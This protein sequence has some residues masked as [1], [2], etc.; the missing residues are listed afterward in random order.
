M[1][2][3]AGRHGIVF[4]T[5]I[6]DPIICHNL[7]IVI[8][9]T[10]GARIPIQEP[11]IRPL[12]PNRQRLSFQA[13]ESKKDCTID[14]SHA[15]TQLGGNTLNTAIAYQ[16]TL[17]TFAETGDLADQT[18]FQSFITGHQIQQTLRGVFAPQQI[19]T[20]P[21]TQVE[22]ARHG[23]YFKPK[24]T[25]EDRYLAHTPSYAP[26]VHDFGKDTV[27]GDFFL[28][29]T[30]PKTNVWQQLLRRKQQAPQTRIILAPGKSLPPK[31]YE[32]DILSSTNLLAMNK[33]EALEF[34]LQ[35]NPDALKQ[36]EQFHG[37]PLAEL[38]LRRIS[39]ELARAICKMGPE[40]ALVTNGG[41]WV[42]LY[43]RV[44]GRLIQV[45][46]PSIEGI[47]DVVR[48]AIGKKL[49][50]KEISFIGCGD[51][52][53]GVFLA[54]EK[55]SQNNAWKLDTAD[56]LRLAVAISRYHSWNPS[57][58]I[59]NITSENLRAIAKKVVTQKAA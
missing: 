46:P 10:D 49:G 29:T 52:L 11:V 58:N 18:R 47:Q 25:G 53:L 34:L 14:F 1:N 15:D 42:S 5:R 38:P 2:F 48:E 8:D 20:P 55:L 31:A 6:K 43:N 36:I 27:P 39:E 35:R 28:S 40:R 33:A 23:Y 19:N 12:T 17:R 37:A 54:M 30:N 9:D 50:N 26:D 7:K 56:Q 51:T 4:D 57:P 59:A 13:R 32:N 44:E 45:E 22:Y 21:K 41:T 24:Q 16:R 3:L